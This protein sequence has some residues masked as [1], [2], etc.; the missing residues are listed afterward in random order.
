MFTRK[1]YLNECC[2]HQQYYSQFISD[3]TRHAVRET[4]GI[5]RIKSSTDPHFNDIPLHLWDL[6]PIGYRPAQLMK[7]V[8]DTMTAAGKICICKEAARQLRDTGGITLQIATQA[9]YR[10]ELHHKTLKNTDGTPKKC[11]VNGRCKT[12]KTRPGKF[13]LP[14]KQYPNTYFYITEDNGDDWGLPET[15]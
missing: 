12:W 8:G 2:T 5:A 15:V 3:Y 14:V 11:R 7:Q 9:G 13:R 10:Q 1:D 6:I 4:L